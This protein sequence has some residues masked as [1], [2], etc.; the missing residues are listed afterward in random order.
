MIYSDI[1]AIDSRNGKIADVW[2]GN[3]DRLIFGRHFCHQGSVARTSVLKKYL[4][5]TSFKLSADSDQT[6]RMVANDELILHSPHSFASYRSG[7]FSNLNPELNRAEHSASFYKHIGNKVGLSRDDC[8]MLWNF[9]IF[10]ETTIPK[11]LLYAQKLLKKEWQLEFLLEF[12][13]LV[14][15][16]RLKID[17][18][19][20]SVLS[21]TLSEVKLIQK[22]RHLKHLLIPKDGIL[23]KLVYRKR[24]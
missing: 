6:I 9:S 19:D 14:E 13:A 10:F 11:S 5:D 8:Y 16:K 18:S 7:G 20:N 22:I 4:F 12:S 3:I 1:N 15:S 23:Y 17:G 2:I 21:L 24:K